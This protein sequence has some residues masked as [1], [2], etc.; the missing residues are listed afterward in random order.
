MA[1]YVY[2][3]P[4]VKRIF[5]NGEYSEEWIEIRRVKWDDAQRMSG[6]TETEQKN[7]LIPFVADWSITNESGEKVPIGI[8][9]MA[10]LPIEI[11][12]PAIQY[13]NELFLGLAASAPPKHD[14]SKS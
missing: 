11:V 6:A 10:E 7:A 2:G 9:T 13:F 1:K 12:L 5:G 3:K 8:E 14:N 4:Q